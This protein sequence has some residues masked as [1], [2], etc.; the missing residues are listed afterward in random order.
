[1]T[2]EE[3]K[4]EYAR[5]IVKVGAHVRKDQRVLLV[6]PVET[7]EFCRLVVKYAYEE[8]AKEVVVRYDDDV[9]ERM[10]FENA[11]MEVFATCPEWRALEMNTYAKTDICFIALAG[12]DPEAM[13]GV[14]PKKLTASRKANHE[15]L[16]DWYRLQSI[17]GF[18]WTIVG[19]PT[20]AWATKVYPDLQADVAVTR[21]WDAVFGSVRIGSGDACAAWMAHADLLSKKTKMLTDYQFRTLHYTNG[22]GTDFTVGLVKNHRWEG[23]ADKDPVDGQRFFA[24]MPTEECFTMPDNRVAEGRLVASLPLSYQGSLIDGF[25][26]TFK[27][28]KVVAYDAKRGKEVLKTLLETDEGST[29]LGECALVPYPSPVSSQGILFLET[30]FDENAACHFALGACYETNLQGG[31]E[32]NEEELASHGA[33]QSVNHVDFMVGT[34]DLKVVGTTWDGKEVTVF[35][36]GTWAL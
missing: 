30:L 26:F 34:A 23:G 4:D 28:G 9:T 13:K 12:S 8:G 17:M 1:M 33:N 6:S 18:K 5:L 10:R 15:A 35:E 25:E 31:A 21:L 14:D 16:K 20:K 29:R 36:N 24:N 27:D 2:F 7:Y 11:P 32:M 22:L 19:V 3:K